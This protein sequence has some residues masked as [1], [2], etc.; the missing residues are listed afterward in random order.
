MMKVLLVG[1]DFEYGIERYYIKY[2]RQSGVEV[3]HY[4]APDIVF[5]KRSKNLLSKVLFKAGLVTRYGYVNRELIRL[6]EH[7]HPDVIWVFKGMEI[8]PSTLTRLRRKFKLANY[9]PDHPF[10]ISSRGSGNKNVTNSV[11]LYH[12]HFCYNRHLQKQIEDIYNIKTVYLPFGFE[13]SQE[14]F[15]AATKEPEINRICFIGNPDKVRV[16]I[17]S[18]LA[19]NGFDVDIYG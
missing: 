8:Y 17:I 11:G 7:H 18:L 2:L 15:L 12:L 14:E 6:S 13:L 16:E 10:I 19:K 9:N 4:A 3:I 5:G 1:S